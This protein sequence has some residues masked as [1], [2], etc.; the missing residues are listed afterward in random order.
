MDSF[1]E[2]D[3]HTLSAQDI[4]IAIYH[5]GRTDYEIEVVN[6]LKY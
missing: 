4:I 5:T 3:A 1:W 6:I 2:A